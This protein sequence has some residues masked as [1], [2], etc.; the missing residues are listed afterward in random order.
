[1]YLFYEEF[2]VSSDLKFN[3]A[4]NPSISESATSGHFHTCRS[5]H[6]DCQKSTCHPKVQDK[7][8]LQKLWAESARQ[9]GLGHWDPFTAE[10]TGELPPQQTQ[11][12]RD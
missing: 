3:F 12:G 4:E 11:P 7:D 1:M 6:S 8:L 2:F 5:A 9:V 10:D